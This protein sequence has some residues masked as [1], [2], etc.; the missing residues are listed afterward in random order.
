MIHNNNTT[1]TTTQ[2][3]LFL[4]PPGDRLPNRPNLVYPTPIPKTLYIMYHGPNWQ[5][6]GRMVL[7]TG[8]YTIPRLGHL[9]PL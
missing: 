6:N 1:T 7:T 3:I 4:V 2:Q 9:Y 5:S 8:D